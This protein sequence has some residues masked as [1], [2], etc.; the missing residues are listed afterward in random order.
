MSRARR[1]RYPLSLAVMN[2]DQSGLI[3]S[4][5]PPRS[6]R[7]AVRKVAAFLQQHLREEDVLAR[8]EGITFALLLPDVPEEQARAILEKLQARL[9][10]T[11]FE[12]ESCGLS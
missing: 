2:I 6:H 5:V 4:S 1:N 3:H 11:A 12:L 10:S 7:E 9:A 8:L